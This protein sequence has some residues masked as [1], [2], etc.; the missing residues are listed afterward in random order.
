MEC[1]GGFICPEG[2]K[3]DFKITD[4][5]NGYESVVNELATCRPGY[6]CYRRV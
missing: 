3:G 5:Y 1:P 4:F 6:Y 2:L